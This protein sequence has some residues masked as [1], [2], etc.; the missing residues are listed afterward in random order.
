MARL[1]LT[2]RVRFAAAHRYRRPEW[3]NER[4]EKTF[5][6]CARESY[7]GHTYECDVTVTGALDPLTG[8]VAD[9]GVLDDVLQRVVVGPLDHRNLN[10]DVPEF[11]EGRDIPSGE[12]LSI[13]IAERVQKALPPSVVVTRVVVR[14]DPSLWSTWE[15]D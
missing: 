5:G 10:V 11:S 3:D 14:E 13:W 2:R 4:N 8:F 15:R 7:H 6:L 9:L 12:N 1:T